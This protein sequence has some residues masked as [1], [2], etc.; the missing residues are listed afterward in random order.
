MNA[1]AGVVG[2]EFRKKIILRMYE[3]GKVPPAILI[4]GSEG[5]G[6]RALAVEMSKLLMCERDTPPCGDCRSCRLALRGEHPD[7]LYLLPLPA[8]ERGKRLDWVKQLLANPYLPIAFTASASI[9][10]DDI[11]FLEE[12]IQLTPAF[13]GNKVA[14]IFDAH[15]MTAEA[16]NAFLKTL[17]EPPS[18]AHI[19]LTT[20]YPD[21]LFETIVSRTQ[22]FFLGRLSSNEIKGYLESRTGAT[23]AEIELVSRLSEGSLGRAFLLLDKEYFPT[24]KRM[25]DLF[26]SLLRSAEDDLLLDAVQLFQ[27]TRDKRLVSIFFTTSR[28]VLNDIVLYQR[29]REM[30]FIVNID[31]KDEIVEVARLLPPDKLEE[32]ISILDEK[33][34]FLERNPNL[35]VLVFDFIFRLAGREL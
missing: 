29:T 19:I 21:R 17:E 26:F 24:R 23:E 33:M 2:Q 8:A 6:L 18:Y 10:I 34:S 27:N 3:M 14:I 16:Q 13:G 22:R 7:I 12:Q 11:R 31:R 35:E 32:Y 1:L 4:C 30:E 15:R 9:T 28:S 5:V 20:P 25:L